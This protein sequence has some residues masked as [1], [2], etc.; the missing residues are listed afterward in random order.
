MRLLTKS[1]FK[2]GLEC[3]NKLYYIGKKDYSN[4]KN[5]DPFL[6]ALAQGGFQVEELARMHYPNGILIEGNPWEYEYAW[7]QTQELLKQ[8]NVIIYEA[9]FLFDGLFIRTD[10]LV[11][12]GNIIELIEVKSK[13]FTPE[14]EYLL[15]GKRGGL[16]SG[17]KSYL[18]DVAFQ[19]YVIQKS[20][21]KW[22]IRSFLMMVDKSKKTSINGLNQL[23]RITNQGN[24][25]TEIIK[26]VQTLQ[27]T[28][29]SVLGRK[30]ISQ[31]ISDI[32][33]NKFIYH[34][35]LMFL[36]AI[37]LFRDK[38]V[39]DEYTN[40][41]T[42]FTSCKKCEFK[43]GNLEEAQGLKSGFKECFKKQHKWTSE[44]F[45]KPNI[46]DIHDFRKGSKLFESGIYFKSEL[47]EENIG[48]KEEPERLTTSHRQWLQIEKENNKDSSIHVDTVGLK[49]EISRFNYPL[50]FIDFETS[51]AALPFNKGLRPY[52]QIAF[53][54]SHHIY[55][56]DGSIVH[57]NEYINNEASV[58][59]NFEFI[60]SLKAALEHDNGTIFRYS[61]HENT[62]LN[63]IYIQLLNSNEIDK[64]SL[65]SFIQSISH[66]TKDS[67][68]KWKG[69][70]DMVDL[71][72]IEKRYYYN[73]LTNGSNSLKAV[74]PSSLA[75]SELL[76]KKYSKPINR[77]NVTSKNFPDDHV[78]LV[79]DNGVVKNP[80]KIL[81][82]VFEGWSEEQIE[83]TLS[84]IEDIAN[85]G[86]A[87]IAYSKLQYTDM[88]RSEIDGLTNSLLKYCE[89][90][91]LAM[92]MIY[93]HFK[94]LIE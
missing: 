30:D 68:L 86:A 25:R 63:A 11:K 71:W 9:A 51:A 77:I 73:P 34:S 50:H 21:P 47:T 53:Q 22:E 41:P 29:D 87:L 39:K 81:P 5:E 80:Y 6:E 44:D 32:E 66:S 12:K 59:P 27:E 89:L 70:R 8:D 82:S 54:F 88:T 36:D 4:T 93:E 60:R 18:F 24:S 58:F 28:G 83:N 76:Q 91:T 46:F 56:K 55:R 79:I 74:L 78:W 35:N 2:L 75:K 33:S 14:D 42:A 26:K 61:N 45:L 90:D 17:W 64:D 92:V 62:I 69:E 10:V 19:K 23:F 65:I 52:E 15:V 72:D 16:V 37:Q 84:E 13:S 43:Y 31:I 48:L 40:W 67:V 1:K 7:N 38:Y 57:A 20:F 3:P 94:E 85:G 49:A